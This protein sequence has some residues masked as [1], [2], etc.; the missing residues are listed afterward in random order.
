MSEPRPRATASEKQ[1]GI[2]LLVCAAMVALMVIVGGVTRLTHS[3]LS[4][5]EWK[6]L[7]GTIPPLSDADWTALFDKYKQTPEYRLVNIGMTLEGFQHIFW[8]EYSHRLLGRVIGLVFLCPLLYFVYKKAITKRVAPH[9]YGMFVLGGLQGAMGWYMVASGLVAEPR[10]SPYRLAAHLGLAFAILGWML[11]VAIDL[12]SAPHTEKRARHPLARPAKALVGLVF[13]MILSGAFVAGA[14]AGLQYNTWPLMDGGFAPDGLFVLSPLW[15]NIFENVPLVQ[16]D[17]RMIAY[18]IAVSAVA[19]WVV[20]RRSHHLPRNGRIASHVL[21]AA[22]ALQITLGITTLLMLVPVWLG[23]THQAGAIVLF[24]SSIWV[25][26]E[27][28]I[29]DTSA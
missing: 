20:G 16:L 23:A 19:I 4:I 15:R 26:R 24:A 25:A 28:H 8:W 3:G 7:V 11:W 18:L 27:L 29:A 6:P 9:L 5:V 12:I 14:H 10:V 22:V 2:W 13:L 1:V 21:L 17:H